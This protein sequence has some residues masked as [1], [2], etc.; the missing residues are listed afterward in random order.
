MQRPVSY[1]ELR[2]N[3]LTSKNDLVILKKRSTVHNK[4][5]KDMSGDQVRVRVRVCVYVQHTDKRCIQLEFASR[6]L[7][8]R[9]IACVCLCTSSE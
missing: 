3:K 8:T 4:V 5:G 6:Y 1:Q 9:C 7:R 2:R